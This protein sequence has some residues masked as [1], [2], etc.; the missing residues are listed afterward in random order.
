LGQTFFVLTNLSPAV[1]EIL[2][3]TSVSKKEKKINKK[4]KKKEKTA[5]SICPFL[6]RK[7]TIIIEVDFYGYTSIVTIG[8]ITMCIKSNI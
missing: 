2:T 4:E 6:L 5:V 8:I 1:Y 3:K 7:R